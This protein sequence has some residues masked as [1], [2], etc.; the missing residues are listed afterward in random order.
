MMNL[1]K[2]LNLDFSS[3]MPNWVEVGKYSIGAFDGLFGETISILKNKEYLLSLTNDNDWSGNYTLEW[4]PNPEGEERDYFVKRLIRSEGE[5]YSLMISPKMP[6]EYRDL[7]INQ[8]SFDRD[9]DLRIRFEG[10]FPLRLD[11]LRTINSFD[12]FQR[13]MVTNSYVNLALLSYQGPWHPKNEA[14]S[15]SV[16]FNVMAPKDEVVRQ[17]VKEL[18]LDTS[19]HNEEDLIITDLV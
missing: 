4:C 9:N 7:I 16:S 19:Q 2:K 12:K 10:S 17:K 15:I 1:I 5:I 6:E 18:F 14:S 11:Q 3:H 13:F 8:N